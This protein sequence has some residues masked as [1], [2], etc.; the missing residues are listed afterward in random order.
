[1]GRLLMW[2]WIAA[3]VLV[4]AGASWAAD[5]TIK[6][7]ATLALNGKVYRLD[8][9]DAP[10]LDQ[11][12]LDDKGATWPCGIAARD[13]LNEFINK[14]AVQCD[15]KGPDTTYRN[16]RIGICRVEGESARLNQWLVRNGWALNFEPYA[17]GRFFFDQA[18]AQHNHHGLWRGCFTAPQDLRQWNKKTAKLLGQCPDDKTARAVLFPDHPDMPPG[19]SIKGRIAKRAQITGDR[20]I[21]HLEGCRSYRSLT[22]PNRWFCTEEDARAAGYRK[23][24]NC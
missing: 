14:R 6:D 1:M 2:T 7:A 11:T 22:T 16:R 15:D 9:I 3:I 4:S 12:C 18:H 24:F 23:A 17:K 19:C 13:Q 8:G 21:Y 10:E 20:G 5:L